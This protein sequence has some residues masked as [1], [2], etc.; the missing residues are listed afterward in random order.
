MPLPRKNG[1]MFGMTSRLHWTPRP[2]G[3]SILM[4][5]KA[6]KDTPEKRLT[7]REIFQRTSTYPFDD[8]FP[9]ALKTNPS[10]GPAAPLPNHP[11]P[12]MS[13]LKRIVLKSMEHDSSIEKVIVKQTAPPPEAATSPT[14]FTKGSRKKRQEANIGPTRVW[15]WELVDASKSEHRTRWVEETMDSLEEDNFGPP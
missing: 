3:E 10:P 7:T 9:V 2:S 1:N 13:Y 12:S 14:H 11:V 5:L 8:D 4:V 6:L 15:K